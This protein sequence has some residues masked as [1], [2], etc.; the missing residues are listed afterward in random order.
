VYPAELALVID[1]WPWV[2]CVSPAKIERPEVT[3]VV[4]AE[5]DE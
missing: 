3:V 2:F 5:F 1:I 4:A